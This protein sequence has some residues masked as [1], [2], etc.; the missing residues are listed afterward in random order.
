M[1]GNWVQVRATYDFLFYYGINHTL[2]NKKS[3]AVNPYE[4]TYKTTSIIDNNQKTKL[5]SLDVV[6]F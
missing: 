1:I 3:D 6:D 5:T 4:A 2:L